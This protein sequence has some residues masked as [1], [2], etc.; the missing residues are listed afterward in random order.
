MSWFKVEENRRYAG[1]DKIMGNISWLLIALVS[2]DIKLLPP[3]E[4]S[5]LFLAIFCFF[6]LVYNIAAR[7][8][9]F[10]GSS[11]QG[12]TFIDLM[13]F[14]CFIIAVSWYTGKITSPFI[15]LI[16]I[17][18]MT[19]SLTQGKRVTYFMAILAVSSYVLLA[20]EQMSLILY[21]YTIISHVLELFPFM[22]IAH[23]GA[24]LSGEAETAR[25][26]IERL[27]L[28]DEITGLN[29]MRNFFNLA[30]AQ[31]QVSE[32]YEKNYAIC[33]VDADNLKL[34]NDKHGHFAG[35]ALIRHVAECIARN[36][37]SSDIAARY[38]GDEF[39]I[40]YPESTKDDVS[41]AVER[42][43]KSVEETPFE[44]EGVALST[45]LSAGLASFPEDGVDLKNVM[46]R[47]D[48]AMYISKK[49]GKNRL[50]HYSPAIS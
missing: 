11:S 18:L 6:L 49:R 48:E 24:M 33:M 8:V 32:R 50:T 3:D 4:T 36:V 23:L 15:S 43:L 16:Y 14:L 26:E 2:L 30:K 22:L 21:K 31:E 13:V 40:L 41:K 10:S 28:T 1:Y 42:I 47:S 5:T 19:T 9:V 44:Y 35:T 27:S 12:K 46:A 39:I 29:N 17:I 38:G 45:T 34:V 20:S 7:Y 25:N 37:R